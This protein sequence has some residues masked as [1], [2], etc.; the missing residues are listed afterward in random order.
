MTDTLTYVLTIG[1]R[2]QD[3]IKETVWAHHSEV[4]QT[5][6]RDADALDVLMSVLC[7]GEPWIE[8]EMT[9]HS[10]D[11]ERAGLTADQAGPMTGYDFHPSDISKPYVSVYFRHLRVDCFRYDLLAEFSSWSESNEWTR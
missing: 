4:P 5:Q 8:A 6:G 9:T 10:F 11:W 3:G 1:E 2:E 7:E